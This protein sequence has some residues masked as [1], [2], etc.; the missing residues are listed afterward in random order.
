ML[1]A[2]FSHFKCLSSQS[3]SAHGRYYSMYQNVIN[4][5]Q[6]NKIPAFSSCSTWCW[7]DIAVNVLPD[8]IVRSEYNVLRCLLKCVLCKIFTENWKLTFC[9]LEYILR[10][11]HSHGLIFVGSADTYQFD[12]SM[13]KKKKPCID[14]GE[15]DGKTVQYHYN[16]FKNKYS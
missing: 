6:M 15:I 9:T 11:Y 12:V 8:F 7:L 5:H 3:S 4:F 1:T 13:L 10:R 14:L 16:W 2:D